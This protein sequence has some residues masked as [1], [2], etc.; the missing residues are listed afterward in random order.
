MSS[1]QA[2]RPPPRH[3]PL[4]GRPRWSTH[5]RLLRWA[6]PSP[7][8]GT[9]GGKPAHHVSRRCFRQRRPR[10]RRLRCTLE[11]VRGVRVAVS[12]SVPGA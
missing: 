4:G 9:G 10:R 11:R 6:P 5:S 3:P 2:G 12:F 8:Y 7:A 1:F